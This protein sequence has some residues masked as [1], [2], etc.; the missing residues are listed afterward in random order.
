MLKEKNPNRIKA[1]E[2]Y[3]QSY[4]NITNKKIAL[5]LN[6][7]PRNISY[8][9]KVDEWKKI[10]NPNGGAPIGNKNAV[11]NK[12]GGAPIGNQN[13][14]KDGWYSKYF[15]IESKS[16]IKELEEANADPLEILWAQIITLWTAI[17]RS[18]KIMFVSDKNDIT[19]E[20]KKTT[21]GDKMDSQEY[22]IQFA[23][24]KQA[25]FLN[26]QSRAMTTLS[27]MIKRYD[28]M[29][30]ANWEMTTEEQRLR[31]DKLRVQI[32]N[33]ELQHRKEVSEQKLKMQEELISMKKK[34]LELKEW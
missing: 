7:N 21:V 33:P 6:E 19:K 2:I 22:E 10:Y 4:G 12:G 1:F 9:K 34:E 14:R 25:N 24:D 28:D 5:K 32:D 27:N 8:W 16:I 18:Q 26:A 17:I 11:G 29:L 23:W 30:H 13:S 20:L 15:P 3:K 31:V